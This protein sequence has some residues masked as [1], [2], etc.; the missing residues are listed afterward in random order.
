MAA[1]R[2]LTLNQTVTLIKQIAQAHDQINTVYFGDVWEFLAQT[3]NIYPAMFYSLT[4][5]NISGRT[6]SLNFSL[7]FLDRQL[8]NESNETEVLSDQLLIAQDIFSM[9]R[10]PNFD[11]KLDE[12]V[13]IEFFTEEDKDYLA[14]VKM[15]VIVNY[16][17][18]TDRCQVP[19]NFNYPL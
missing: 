2:Q 19:A 11:W 1:P 9:M 6:L 4:G 5:S 16:P 18:L 3:D 7:F 8:Q 13:S 12:S 14:G 10:H 17:M 15:D